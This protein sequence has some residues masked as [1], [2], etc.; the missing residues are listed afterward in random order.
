L[1]NAGC[2]V[3]FCPDNQ[4]MYTQKPFLK[5]DFSHLDKI[6]EGKFRPGH[7]SGVALIVSKLFH[8]VQPD[9]AYFGQKD[10][11]QFVIIR[12]LVFDLQFNI[13]LHCIPTMREPDGLAMS[14]RN[15][16][17]SADE[18]KLS[19]VFYQALIIAKQKLKQGADINHVKKIVDELISGQPKTSLEYFELADSANLNLLDNVSGGSK[20]I[21]CIAG[22]IGEIRLIDN[23]FLD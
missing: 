8:I 14:S 13:T 17:L 12:Q 19:T 3:L 15:L 18:R 7:F 1:D 16:R 21:L 2:D 10:F 20:P 5:F 4:E 11:Q 23:M 22:Y 9:Q 6:M